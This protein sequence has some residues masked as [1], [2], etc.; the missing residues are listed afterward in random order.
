MSDE[1]I[2]HRMVDA[3]FATCHDCGHPADPD[4]HPRAVWRLYCHLEPD[5]VARVRSWALDPLRHPM[6]IADRTLL[7]RW[8]DARER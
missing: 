7:L 5:T 2:A 3:F 8:L 4:C 1:L 6:G